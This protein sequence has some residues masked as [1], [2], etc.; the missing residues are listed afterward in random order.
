MA[1]MVVAATLLVL[2]GWAAL[3]L[4]RSQEPPTPLPPYELPEATAD[5]PLPPAPSE[6]LAD[7]QVLVYNNG[8]EP[9]TLDP[10]LMQGVPG[11]TIALALFE[12]LTTLHPKTLAPVP[13]VAER[14][15]ISPDG[16]VYTFHL[17]EAR[18]SNGQPLTA[19][20]FV[21][22]WRRALDP[23][24]ATFYAEMLYP[25]SNAEPLNKGRLD[26]ATQL[27][28]QATD[29][30][31][32]A[33]RLEHP[34]P[35]FL[36]LTAFATY[37]PVNRQCI[38]RH[39][40]QWTRPRH[41]VSN[42]PFRL[43]EH[44]PRDRIILRKNPEYW[45][46]ERV[47]LEEIH[48]LA[49]D[50]SETALKKFQAG[51]VDWIRDIPAVKVAEAAQFPGFRYTPALGT[52][53]Y[54]FNVTRPPLDDRRVRRALAMAIDKASIARYLCRAGQRPARSFVPPVF[55]DYHPATGPRHGPARARRLLADAGFPEGRGFPVLEI[56]YNTS[57]AHKAIAETIQYMWRTELGIRVNLRNQE[58]KVYLDSTNR[59]RYDVARSAWIG[60][61]NDPSTFLDM[62][63]TG[64]GN[65][66][67][68]WSS[69]RYD[70]RL[71]QARQEPDP[72]K[73][74]D[75]LREAEAILVDEE[76]PIVPLYFYVYTYL[77]RPK[78]RGV[79]D[80]FR[81]VHPFQYMYIAAE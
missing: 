41:M 14:W 66:R 68:G 52:Y 62:F 21:Y 35:Y 29:D 54:R 80:N 79:F 5:E 49:I 11:H 40:D 56:L 47:M 60:D 64:G 65:N 69:E 78:V 57:D 13:G 48:A 12:G 6:P 63:V 18:W 59:L 10:T 50:D 61:Y 3:L 37:A 39:G 36:Q 1:Q 43:A 32:L 31:T 25:V 7:Q 51:E 34:L 22:S 81:N 67:T 38:E 44:R 46:A 58:W 8:A 77:V 2:G 45:N 4:A 72:A 70:R 42:G 23:A 9:Q 75:L 17:R 26:D 24:T 20:D 27:G 73:R 19:Q 74:A 55:P 28:V 30:R 15:D 33:V 71:R 53:F 76:M 16:T